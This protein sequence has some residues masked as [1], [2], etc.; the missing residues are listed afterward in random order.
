LLGAEVTSPVV[1]QT[2]ARG[3][4][5]NRPQESAVSG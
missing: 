1:G 3:Y 4:A 2:D 5:P